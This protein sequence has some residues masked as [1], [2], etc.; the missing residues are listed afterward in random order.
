MRNDAMD[1]FATRLEHRFTRAEV[2]TM[3]KNAGLRD[4]RFSSDIPFWTVIGYRA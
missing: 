4:I 2:E 1:R 3:M